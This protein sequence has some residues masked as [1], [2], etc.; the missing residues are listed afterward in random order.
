MNT[1]PVFKTAKK[2]PLNS[3]QNTANGKQ[4]VVSHTAQG[5]QQ[6]DQV[7]VWTVAALLSSSSFTVQE[8]EEHVRPKSRRWRLFG[9]KCFKAKAHT[10]L[11]QDQEQQQLWRVFFQHSGS[12]SVWGIFHCRLNWLLYTLIIHPHSTQ[13]REQDV[14]NAIQQLTIHGTQ[15]HNILLLHVNSK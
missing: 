15:T 11:T 3:R 9:L 10:G 1:S 13:A 7:R 8:E 2:V 12:M 4:L 6:T 14:G 5:W